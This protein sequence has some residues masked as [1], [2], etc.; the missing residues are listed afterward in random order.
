M[1]KFHW[2]LRASRL[3]ERPLINA[4]NIKKDIYYFILSASCAKF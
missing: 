3:A 2:I 4:A 1:V